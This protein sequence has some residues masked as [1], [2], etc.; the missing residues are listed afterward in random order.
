MATVAII[1]LMVLTVII[2]LKG[3]LSLQD[4]GVFSAVT[5]WGSLGL[6]VASDLDKNINRY[7]SAYQAP[8]G[9]EQIHENYCCCPSF[10]ASHKAGKTIFTTTAPQVP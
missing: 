3:G 10:C 9:Y 2:R 7:M 8:R 6:R 4:V 5:V 1:I